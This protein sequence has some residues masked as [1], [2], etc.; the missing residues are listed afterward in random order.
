MP[1]S[2]IPGK[3]KDRRFTV[4]SFGSLAHLNK[5]IV[6]G[7][8]FLVVVAV[9]YAGTMAWISVLQN[10]IDQVSGEKDTLLALTRVDEV[11][12]I[13]SFARLIRALDS[14]IDNH[15]RLSH[16]F[17]AI[18]ENAHERVVFTSFEFGTEKQK[19]EIAGSVPDF[20]S[21]GEQFVLWR[22]DVSLVKDVELEQFEK[23]S[24]GIIFFRANLEIADAIFK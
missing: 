19:L 13:R 21:L 22:D 3:K 5:G 1:T 2:L 9:A 4:T 18:E 12:E 10:E 7:A 20:E 11:S 17:G 8:F 23:S 14:V 16:L 15:V 24:E 6:V